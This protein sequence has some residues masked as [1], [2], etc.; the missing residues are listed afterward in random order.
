MSKAAIFLIFYLIL[1][2][3]L[4]TFKIT[5]VPP[6]IN[7]DEASIGYSAILVA[8]SGV[9]QNGKFLPLFVSTPEK[10]DWK[11]PI[12]FYATVLAF[13][14][15]GSSYFLL[16]LVS[17][18]IILISSF[19]IFL[20]CKEI[21][22]VKLAFVSLFIFT[23]IPAV[24]IQSHLALENIAPLP[25]I[26][27]WLLMLLKYKNTN[28]EKYLTFSA[29]SLGVSIFSYTAIRIIFPVFLI[30]S[31]L[32]IYYVGKK[33]DKSYRVVIKFVLI[34]LIFPL[35]LLLTKNQYPGAILQNNR[36]TKLPAYQDFILP[37]ISSF[38][39][40]FLFITGDST[41]Y[42]STGKQGVF[43]LATL[44]LFI[45]GVIRIIQKKDFF[46]KFILSGLFL[47]PLLYGFPESIHRGSRLLVLLPFFTVIATFGITSILEIKKKLIKN[48]LLIIIVLLIS[49]NYFDFARDY[50]YEYPQRVKA[51]FA[52]PYQIVFDRAYNLSKEKKLPVYLQSGLGTENITAVEFFKQVYFS[53]T[54][55]I[56]KEDN[57]FKKGIFIVSDNNLP[58]YKNYQQEK[59]GDFGYGL[60]IND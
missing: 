2:F 10:S 22:G 32:Y 53:E 14:L 35:F 51:E 9:D 43:L 4:L 48:L 21:V 17:V 60:I 11:Q 7:G 18:A 24:L 20:L 49:L 25:F 47:S 27:L 59:I 33:S 56:W 57:I 23:T 38:D 54:I 37:F 8:K 26:I 30:L 50:W 19:L 42:H 3:F 28:K 39:L 13:K 40:S 31:I 12:T 1:E 41:P 46:L 16:R 52:L 55:K 5:E 36:L 29:I 45:L 34:A 6:G 58:K 15:F 44:P